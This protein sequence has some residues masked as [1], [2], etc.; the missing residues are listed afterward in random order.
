MLKHAALEETDVKLDVLAK[1]IETDVKSMASR[2]RQLRI[3]KVGISTLNLS[4]K[5]ID[6]VLLGIPGKLGVASRMIALT[7]N[8]IRCS[9][10]ER[11]CAS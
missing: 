10:P 3:E 7:Q 4:S 6:T 5:L 2:H 11:S 9:W 8:G 1:A